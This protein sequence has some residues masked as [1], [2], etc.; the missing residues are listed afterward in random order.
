MTSMRDRQSQHEGTPAP[1]ASTEA[2]DSRPSVPEPV[3]DRDRDRFEVRSGAEVLGVLA[4][5]DDPPPEADA[6]AEE[7]GARPV[8]DLRSTVVDP[9]HGGR[10]VGSALVRAALVDARAQGLTVRATCWFARGWIERHPEVHD[11]VDPAPGP[12]APHL[13]GTGDG[14]GEVRA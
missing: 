7:D 4:Y 3:H 9:E 14:T 5:S 13:P 8:R 1:V 12:G 2:S 6:G 11:L 10:G